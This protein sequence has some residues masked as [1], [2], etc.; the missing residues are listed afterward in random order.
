MWY[1]VMYILSSELHHDERIQHGSYLQF[2]PGVGQILRDIGPGLVCTQNLGS[3]QVFFDSFMHS[4]SWGLMDDRRKNHLKEV[5]ENSS[6]IG[7]F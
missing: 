1:G 7:V 4:S 2:L 5:T 6:L 3:Q